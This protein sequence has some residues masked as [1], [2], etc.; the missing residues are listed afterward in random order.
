MSSICSGFISI[1]FSS[2]SIKYNIYCYKYWSYLIL[3]TLYFRLRNYIEIIYIK[4]SISLFIIFLGESFAIII[5]L[6]QK[7]LLLNSNKQLKQFRSKDTINYKDII[8]IDFMI[9]ICSFCDLIGCYNFQIMGNNIK[10]V[11][12]I[13]DMIFLCIFI[14]L[15]E[16]F[17]LKI[18]IYHYYI[19]GYGLLIISL[20][21]DLFLKYKLFN[22]KL[23]ILIIISLESQY[24][25]S[26]II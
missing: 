9:F 22:K 24:I 7:F 21:I 3:R 19:L 13:F 26:L 1:I 4:E 12:N 14:V 25:E 2:C 8:K 5:Y 18:P 17:Y 20:L 11:K 16:N 23:I 15:N 6:Y 10:N